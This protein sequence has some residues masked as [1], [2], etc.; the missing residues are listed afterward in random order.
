LGVRRG[1]CIRTGTRKEID[2]S[3]VAPWPALPGLGPPGF[4]DPLL[5]TRPAG[6][7]CE[8]T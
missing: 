2:L 6:A 7:G 1:L 8:L 5:C 3:R 4:T